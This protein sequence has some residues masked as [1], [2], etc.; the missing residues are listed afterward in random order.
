[1][2]KRLKEINL[3]LSEYSLGKFDKRLT[4][5]PRLDDIDAIISGINMLG[6]EL[7]PLLY[8]GMILLIFSILFPIWFLF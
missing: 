7:K 8:Q 1:M 6:E 3:R 5:S 2:D 4:L